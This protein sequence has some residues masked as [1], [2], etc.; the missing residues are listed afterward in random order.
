MQENLWGYGKRLL[1]VDAEATKRFGSDR[2]C[3]SVLDIGCGNGSQLAIPLAERGY[4]VTGVDPNDAS[5]RRARSLCA[6]AV[7][8]RGFVPD[9][10]PRQLF[11]IVIVSEVLEHLTEPEALLETAVQ[12]LSLDGLLIV[13]V[14]N[15]YGE[16]EWDSR[17]Y[18]ALHLDRLFNSFCSVLRFLLRRR[19]R[20]E[21]AGSDDL[22]GHVQ[23]FTLSRLRAMFERNNLIL[24]NRRASS[25][26]S[27]PLVAHTLARIP[28]FISSNAHIADTIP[29]W[30]SS[31]W[32]FALRRTLH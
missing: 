14:P 13:T 11:T 10:L 24:V 26:I 28:K 23:R 2:S 22:A 12:Y 9:D 29:L 15:G 4:R 5:I 27:G 25:F 8:V 17:L 21:F 1:F 19:P 16:F 31:G 20:D 6:D 7:F 30:A 3:I 32:M 18:K